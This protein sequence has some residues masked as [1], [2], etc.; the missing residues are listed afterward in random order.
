MSKRL[1]S[2]VASSEDPT[3]I[4]NRVKG[5]VLALSSVIIFMGAQF[6]NITLTAD[7]V[8]MLASQLG[9]VA[10]LVWALWGGILALVRFF[11]EVKD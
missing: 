7:D 2:L 1:G 4:S 3:Q 10:G 9:T 8:V 11:A 6:F 5:V